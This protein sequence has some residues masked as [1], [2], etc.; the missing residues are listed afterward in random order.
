[1]VNDSITLFSLPEPE[2]TP[3]C[4]QFSNEGYSCVTST[5]CI[6]GLVVDDGLA[7]KNIGVRSGTADMKNGTCKR[8]DQTCCLN[9]SFQTLPGK[10]LFFFF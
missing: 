5:K 4:A 9:P 10:R 2:P 7:D 1:L 8:Q 3:D 6:D